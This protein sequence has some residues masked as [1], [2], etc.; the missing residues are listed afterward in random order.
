M[1]GV[2]ENLKKKN[3]L[4]VIICDNLKW[5]ARVNYLIE[6]SSNDSFPFVN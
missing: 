3:L 6:K 5:D 1:E 2:N 4:G